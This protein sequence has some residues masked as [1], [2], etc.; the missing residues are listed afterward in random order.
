VFLTRESASHGLLAVDL[1]GDVLESGLELFFLAVF[2]YLSVDT[3]F[4]VEAF[5]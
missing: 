3:K 4:E 1:D 5:N 2:G